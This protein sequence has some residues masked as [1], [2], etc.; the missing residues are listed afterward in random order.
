MF[1]RL[2]MRYIIMICW[3]ISF[4]VLW[5]TLQLSL[6]VEPFINNLNDL[7]ESIV[8]ENWDLTHKN[9]NKLEDTW[10]A[11]KLMIQISNGSTE[12]YE[13]ERTLGHLKTLI[14]HKEDDALE[15]IGTLKV[16]LKNLTDVFPGP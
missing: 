12:V 9:L 13:F 10:Q 5:S 1:D 14:Q 15:Y 4:I 8:N 2:H 16:I 3:I 6:S 11:N 7:E